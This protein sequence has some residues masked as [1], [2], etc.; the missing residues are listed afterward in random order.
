M[1]FFKQDYSVKYYIN[2]GAD[3]S[4]L[5]LG[6]PTYGRSFNLLN[7]EATEIGAPADGAG[8]KGDAT[9]EAGF[10]SYYEVCGSLCYSPLSIYI[11][12]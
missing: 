4:K 3:P 10:L 1:L 8:E 9:R 2:E 12:N 5:V 7:A 11:Q 6:I